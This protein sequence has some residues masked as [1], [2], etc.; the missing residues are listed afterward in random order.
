MELWHPWPPRELAVR[1]T[2]VVA[3]ATCRERAVGEAALRRVSG[4]GCRPPLVV[5][6]HLH[7][8]SHGNIHNNHVTGLHYERSRC[9]V[10]DEHWVRPLRSKGCRRHRAVPTLQPQPAAHT[11]ARID[12]SR[13]HRRFVDAEVIDERDLPP[14]RRASEQALEPLEQVGAALVAELEGQH[15]RRDPGEQ[16][17]QHPE[18]AECRRV[19]EQQRD[20]GSGR[21]TIRQDKRVACPCVVVGAVHHDACRV[22]RRTRDICH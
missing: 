10:V 2:L 5:V 22:Q 15:V 20:H 9:G 8:I 16:V 3:G 12:A 6:F 21:K 14:R 18:R 4:A 17:A 19:L 13:T 7:A 1:S 11:L